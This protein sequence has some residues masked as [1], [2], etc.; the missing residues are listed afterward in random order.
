MSLSA[1]VILALAIAV[2]GEIA[3]A[4]SVRS[5]AVV[6]EFKRH[7]PCPST[8]LRSGK[9]PGYEID[10]ITPLC[11]HGSDHV[12]NL[13]WMTREDHRLKTRGDMRHCRALRRIEGDT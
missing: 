10:H 13:Q 1:A 9:C 2:Q 4:K 12:S 7:N 3:E 11:A 5:A 8:N 6:S